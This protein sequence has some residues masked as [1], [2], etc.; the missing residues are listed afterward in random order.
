VRFWRS[1]KPCLKRI[2]SGIR[3]LTMAVDHSFLKE[4]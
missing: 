3:Q 2:P 1:L 4:V